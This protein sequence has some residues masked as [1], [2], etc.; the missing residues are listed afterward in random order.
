MELY[1]SETQGKEMAKDLMLLIHFDCLNTKRH[2]VSSACFTIQ[3]KH[4]YVCTKTLLRQQEVCLDSILVVVFFM[5]ILVGLHD[6]FLLVTQEPN[7]LRCFS[8]LLV[9]LYEFINFIESFYF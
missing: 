1:P 4:F 8:Q 6:F 7:G 9:F 5:R 2:K 3:Q